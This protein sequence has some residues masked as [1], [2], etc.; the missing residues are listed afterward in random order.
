MVYCIAAEL[1]NVLRLQ[2]TIA[3]YRLALTANWVRAALVRQ[4]FPL[5]MESL[6]QAFSGTSENL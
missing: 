5:L 1:K 4:P 2:P 3:R 6:L